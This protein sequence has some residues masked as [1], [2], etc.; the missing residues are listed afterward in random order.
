MT[1]TPFAVEI[2]TPQGVAA[3]RSAVLVEAAGLRGRLGV[4]AG[5]EPY[6]VGLAAGRTC[7][8]GA[9]GTRE[10]WSTGPGLMT[11]D[12]QSVVLVVRRALPVA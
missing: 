7:L 5:H 4:M 3:R 1:G 10:E 6:V 2:V 9:D 8:H 12:R 11:I